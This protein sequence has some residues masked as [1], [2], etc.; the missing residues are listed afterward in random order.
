MSDDNGIMQGMKEA[1][2]FAM[3]KD[4]SIERI[5]ELA[6]AERD[7]RVV[8]LPCKVGDI[9]FALSHCGDV[10]YFCDNDYET[11]TGATTCPFEKQC[12]IE[13]CDND[14]LHAFAVEVAGF[15]FGE[16]NPTD[17]AVIVNE[18]DITLS[19]SDFGKRVFVTEAEALRAL[20]ATEP[21]GD[22]T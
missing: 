15:Y 11:G 14:D 16:K 13:E 9:V 19:L 20:A 1:A 8:V 18:L 4:V 5:I 6:E 7:G 17:G 22:A 10:R 3:F 21:K 12:G 2:I